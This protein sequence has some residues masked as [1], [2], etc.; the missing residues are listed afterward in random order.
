MDWLSTSATRPLFPTASADPARFV[1]PSHV[2]RR[3]SN[4]DFSPSQ[5]CQTRKPIPFDPKPHAALDE[6]KIKAVL[7][8]C[9]VRDDARFLA[10]LAFGISSPRITQLGLSKHPVFKSCETTD[11]SALVARFE[12]VCE[13]AG[14]QNGAVLSAAAPAKKVGFGAGKGGAGRGGVGKVGAASSSSGG[15][16]RPSSSASSSKPEAKRGKYD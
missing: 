14:W 7:A 10:R 6:G 3:A 11:F 13:K 4:S 8:V 15:T 1:S 12:E 16:K 9:G 2:S 5:W